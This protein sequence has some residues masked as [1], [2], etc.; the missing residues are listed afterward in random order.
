MRFPRLLVLALSAAS[1]VAPV[2]AQDKAAPGGSFTI[3]KE[4]LT[5]TTPAGWTKAKPANNIVEAEYSVPPAKGDEAPGRLTAM[6]AGGDIE[7][8][9]NRWVDQFAG[10]GGAAAKPKLDKLSVSGCE[11]QIVDLSGTFKDKPG[12]PFAGGATT[13]REN[14]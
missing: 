1:V 4:K 14:Y 12:G 9:I 3:G 10:E 11:V 13:L 7:T 2:A 8:N 6:G 5:F